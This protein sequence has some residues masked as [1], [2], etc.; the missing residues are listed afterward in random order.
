MKL[1]N[2]QMNIVTPIKIQGKKTK[3]IDTI[4]KLSNLENK[5]YV[6]PFLGSGEVL[7]NLNPKVAYVSDNNVHLINFYKSIQKGVITSEK[8]REFLEKNGQRLKETGKDF[9]YYIRDE[10]N[11]THDP[12]LFLFLNRSCFNGVI[13]FNSSGKFNVPFCNKNERFSKSYIT[14]I[15]NQVIKIEE[16]LK[17]H[18]SSWVFEIADWKDTFK[19]FENNEDAFF[20]FDPPYVNRHATY[21]EVWTDSTN[22]DFFSSVKRLRGN[23]LLSNW[24][25][26]KYRTNTE[27]IDFFPKSKY[28][29]FY[30]KHFYHIGASIDNRTFMMECLV[31]KKK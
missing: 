28:N 26:N 6:E 27:L 17:Q 3:L 25:Q 10:F 12:M 29:F 7:F 13:R 24:Y 4:K 8:I 19:K 18:G 2:Q 30:I 11:R 22:N 31:T 23:F 1:G 9:Y 14:K 15:V 20:Y 5:I 21:Y 16:I